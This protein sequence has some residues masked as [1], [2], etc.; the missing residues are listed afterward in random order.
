MKNKVLFFTIIALL[1][2]IGGTGCEKNEIENSLVAPTI[3]ELESP[4]DDP[5]WHPSGKII[6]FNHD[7][8]EEIS[9]YDGNQYSW[10]YN[11]DSTGFWLINSDGTNMR[12]VLPYRL[13]TPAWSPDG[14]WIAFSNDAWQI[15]IMPFDGERF[16]TASVQA[17]TNIKYNVFP[18][19]SPDGK[20]IVYE[21]NQESRETGKYFIWKVNVAG[22]IKKR[23]ADSPRLAA[24]PE[25]YWRQDYSILHKR[26]TK[27]GSNEIFEMDS[28]GNNV[29]RVSSNDVYEKNIRS[30]VDNKYITYVSLSDKSKYTLNRIDVSNNKEMILTEWCLNHSWSPDGEK[31][32]YVNYNNRYIDRTTG[33]L[34]IMD[35]NGN[36]KKPLTY[37]Y[38]KIN[39]VVI[40]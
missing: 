26:Y 38:F 27:K 39:D 14:K 22:T 20:W 12:R 24:T 5:I 31:I 1:L 29:I 25:P 4:Y 21:S 34:W 36:N 35:K 7:P 33:G 2:L 6:G 3:P 16:D 40:E 9:Y 8:I 13:R 17:L 30:S 15:C 19:W 10:K 18:S 11:R 28:N 32:V 23:I 37:N